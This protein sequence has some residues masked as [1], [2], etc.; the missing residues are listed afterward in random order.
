MI[1]GARVTLAFC[2]TA[3]A[4]SAAAQDQSAGAELFDKICAA[5]H[6]KAG[7]GA[8]GLAPP[9]ADRALFA[10]LGEEA[11][12]YLG[13][14]LLSGLTGRIS[15]NGMEY[16]GLVMPSHAGLTDAEV[17]AITGYVLGDLNGVSP[18]LAPAKLAALREAPPDHAALFKMR[19]RAA[20]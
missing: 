10:S 9:L 2:L 13:G 11:P 14:V 8:P 1:I 12:T 4:A 7:A 16:V 15:A 17:L 18:R 6:Q 5:C 20:P 19:E 3:L